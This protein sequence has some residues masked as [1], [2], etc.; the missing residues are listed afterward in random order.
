MRKKLFYFYAF[1]AFIF[2]VS[3]KKE[4]VV[5]N[6]NDIQTTAPQETL[7]DKSSEKSQTPLVANEDLTE[8]VF[9]EKEYDFGTLNDGDK[10]THDFTFKNTGN[11]DL[12]IT[13]AVGSC[14]CTV[15]EYPKEPIPPGQTAKIKVSFNS[16]G[17]KGQQHKSV[18]ISA[19]VPNGAETIAIKAKIKV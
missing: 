1:S 10:V 7:N 18:T 8:M 13:N 4:E 2:I 11:K 5:S 3:C 19:N 12:I 15:P 14:G 17:K 16:T 6:N 9:S